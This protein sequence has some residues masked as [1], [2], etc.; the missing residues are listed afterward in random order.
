MNAREKWLT[1]GLVLL[2]LLFGWASMWQQAR[3]QDAR[4]A[5]RRYVE[6]NER[7]E[8]EDAAHLALIRQARPEIRRSLSRGEFEAAL[9]RLKSLE[10]EDEEAGDQPSDGKTLTIDVLWPPK[11]DGRKRLEA[12]LQELVKKQGQGYDMVPAQQQLAMVAEA[13]RS[14]KRTEALDAFNRAADFAQNAQLRPGFKAPVTQVAAVPG[15]MTAEEL[16]KIEQQIRGVQAFRQQLPQMLAQVQGE[17]RAAL[18]QAQTLFDEMVAAHRQKRDVRPVMALLAPIQ[19]EFAAARESNDWS[20][21]E[22]RLET[23]RAMVKTLPPLPPIAAAAPGAPGSTPP[24]MPGTPGAPGPGGAAPDVPGHPGAVARRPGGQ[25]GV[26]GLLKALDAVRAMPDAEYQARK[27]LIVA[28]LAQ[29]ARQGGL[30]RQA[31]ESGEGVMA[32]VGGDATIYLGHLGEL[33]GFSLLRERAPRGERWGGVFL[34]IDGQRDVPLRGRLE[35]DKSTRF[36][37]VQGEE[38]TVRFSAEPSVEGVQLRVR[39]ERTKEGPPAHLLIAIPGNLGGWYWV[40]ASG[41]E[42]IVVDRE[43]Q[44]QA[45]G[46]KPAKMSLRNGTAE[47]TVEAPTAVAVGYSVKQSQLWVRLPLGTKAGV[48]EHTVQLSGVRRAG[49]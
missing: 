5:V 3:H 35:A 26:E 16:R 34:Q 14:G 43:Y 38:G 17:Q 24:A 46:G 10:A 7:E 41:P 23:A 18:E 45:S 25:P 31:T 49:P 13:A 15:G 12:V 32:G 42:A 39:G 27:P 20:K 36:I 8:K 2:G 28:M 11:S 29:A 21:V 22:Q 47:L 9:K 40:G 33:K 1:A 44:V 37:Q 4:E 48:I 30:M 19:K 6:L